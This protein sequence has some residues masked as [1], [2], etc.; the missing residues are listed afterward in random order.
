MKKRGKAQIT[1]FMI[2][3]VVI[4]LSVLFAVYIYQQSVTVPI[5][6]AVIV[7]EEVQQI[8][9]YVATCAD[10]IGKDGLILLGTQGGYIDIP[11]IIDKNPNA[12]INADP[13]G[14]AKTPMWYYEGEDRTPSL[15]DIQTRLALYIKQNLPACVD[16][17]EAFK[18][19]YDIT[20]VSDI[21]PIVTF[22]DREVIIE[23]KWELDVKVQERIVKLTEFL[24]SFQVNFKS[25]YDL[26]T[27]TM[28]KENEIGWF[29][30][31]TIDLMS[32]NPRIPVS[33]MEFSCGT[34]KM[35]HTRSQKRSTKHVI[36][37][38]PI[39]KN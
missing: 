31:L 16:D 5:E 2:I 34:K 6:R 17:F 23:T 1:L 8:Y 19:R 13:A 3:G 21:V 24:S 32:T 27:K 37:Q 7:P 20:P 9:D 35:A 30:N 33:G 28:E 4:L 29:E 25:M 22:T 12:Y 18:D 15:E 36:L 10:Q 11:K 38:S 14:I 39:C 26:A